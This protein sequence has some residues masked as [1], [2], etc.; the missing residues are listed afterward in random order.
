MSFGTFYTHQPNPRS[1]AILAIAK[2]Q[3]LKLD[4]VY[5]DKGNAKNYE[6]LLTYNPLGQVP[7]FVGADG[8][9]LTECIPIALYLTSQSDTT[10]LLGSSR[11][12][13]FNIQRW[14]S[15]ANSDLLPAIGGVILPLIGKPLVVRKN[16]EDCLHAF[17]ADC[18]LLETHLQKN[19][20]LVGDQVTLADYFV[21]GMLV[22]AV[23][24]F[25]KVLN[26]EYPRLM[27]WF[28]EVYEVPMFKEVAGEL[29]LLDIQYPTLPEHEKVEVNGKH[30]GEPKKINGTSIEVA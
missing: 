18:R 30:E 29:H 8:Y 5:A 25:H 22:F 24:V 23:M 17:H 14:M 15:M 16:S 19:K 27:E 9:V 4:V 26:V 3:G 1:F 6:K 21:V 13:Y 2:G 10:T 11:R 20:Y 28:E 12:D 7:V